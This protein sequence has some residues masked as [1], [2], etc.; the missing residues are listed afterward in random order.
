MPGLLT[1]ARR[2]AAQKK[3]DAVFQIAF[4]MPQVT[5][6]LEAAGFERYWKHGNAFIFEKK[7][8]T[9]A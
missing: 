6:Q 2:F 7:H 5:S 8:P 4:D 3:F 1:D 9:D